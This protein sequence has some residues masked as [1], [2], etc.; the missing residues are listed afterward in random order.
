MPDT[1]KSQPEVVETL[2]D[3]IWQQIQFLARSWMQYESF[4]PVGSNFMPMGRNESDPGGGGTGEIDEEQAALDF[5]LGTLREVLESDNFRI[6]QELTRKGEQNA[7][8][9]AASLKMNK[10]TLQERLSTLMQRGFVVRDYDRGKYRNSPAGFELAEFIRA[11]QT[12]LTERLQAELPSI[13]GSEGKG[14]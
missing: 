5:V 4:V 7:E 9:L 10:L 8:E 2:A 14:E 1:N 11:I 12:G 3:A 6:L 13:L